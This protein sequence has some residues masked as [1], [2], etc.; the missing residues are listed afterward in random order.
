MKG[1][2]RIRWFPKGRAPLSNK[3]LT[4]DLQA[5]LPAGGPRAHSNMGE[6]HV[7]CKSPRNINIL[8]EGALAT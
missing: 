3:A 4:P 1:G 8:A 2:E 6:S 7:K 5:C